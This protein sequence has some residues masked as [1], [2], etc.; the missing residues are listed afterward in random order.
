MGLGFL[1]MNNTKTKGWQ[2]TNTPP[3]V[4]CLE[5]LPH[6][7]VFNYDWSACGGWGADI[8]RK[9]NLS[10]V[11]LKRDIKYRAVLFPLRGT[12]QC[13]WLFATLQA[14]NTLFFPGMITF[15]SGNLRKGIRTP[16][17]RKNFP[18]WTW[19]KKLQFTAKDYFTQRNVPSSS[20]L[21]IFCTAWSSTLCDPTATWSI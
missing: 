6:T 3:P 16:I 7:I 21:G 11:R 8:S 5:V 9:R 17:N 12:A 14:I 19:E 10:I 13:L 1:F 20:P 2:H 4:V 15:L 18:L